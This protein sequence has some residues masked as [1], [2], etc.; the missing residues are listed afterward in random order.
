LVVITCLAFGSIVHNDFVNWDDD[1]NF[2][3]NRSLQVWGWDGVKWAWTTF[4]VG[5]YQPLAWLALLVEHRL[6]RL[7]AEGYHLASLVLYCAALLSCYRLF[8]I[9]LRRADTNGSQGKWL[10]VYAFAVLALF[11][12]H[13]LRV[14]AV[15]WAS[16][17][18]YLLCLL[19]YSAAAAA[20]V[21][22]NRR[23]LA[24]PGV[25]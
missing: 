2:L 24:S 12:I 8:Q 16:C 22:R 11:A 6:W 7:N 9:V 15:A 4:Q 23:K 19:F 13:P 20:Y 3:Q 1:K 10:S 21:M 17:Q 18:P 14:E 5:V 25:A